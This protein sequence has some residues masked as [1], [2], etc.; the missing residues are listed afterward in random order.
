[1]KESKSKSVRLGEVG[2]GCQTPLVQTASKTAAAAA[3]PAGVA[4]DA[5]KPLISEILC[6]EWHLL[7]SAEQRPLLQGYSS[8]I[9]SQEP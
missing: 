2:G 6:R 4:V 5:S 3:A 7:H 8:T 1:L 9:R